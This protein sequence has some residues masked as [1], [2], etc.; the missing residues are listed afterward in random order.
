MKAVGTAITAAMLS[1]GVDITQDRPERGTP[2]T[3]SRSV[4]TIRRAHLEARS[5][6]RDLLRHPAF[7]GF[8]PLILPWDDR[9]Y[10]EQMPLR[11][12]G[13]LLPYHTHVDVDTVISGLNRMIDDAADGKAVFY[14]I[15]D[16]A[17][18]RQQ[19]AKNTRACS[20]SAE[21]RARRSR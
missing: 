18:R 4:S 15:Y 3:V 7:D 2:P 12:I 16:K 1:L 6:L 17:Q 9:T 13:S 21:G 11:R 20:S 5:T 10:D 19:A 14:R 8:A